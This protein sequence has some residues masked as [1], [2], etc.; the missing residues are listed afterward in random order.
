M[1]IKLQ[2]ERFNP[3]AD[4]KPGFQNFTVDAD[5]QSTI[6]EALLQIYENQD[7]TL[8]FRYGCRYKYC[9][10]CSV[11]ADGKAVLACLTRVKNG[12][13]LQPLNHLPVIRDLAVDRRY[14]YELLRKQEI[15]VKPKPK[16][17]FETLK[18]DEAY[19]VLSSCTEC[20]CCLSSC[21]NY[22]YKDEGFAGP[23]LFVKLARLQLDPRNEVDRK[24]Q[25]KRLGLDRCLSCSSFKRKRCVPCPAGISIYKHALLKLVG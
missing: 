17:E 3:E 16:K 22:S 14:L 15:Y 11:R 1:K 6:L 20:L 19:R 8:A 7:S 25:A 21:S 9:G 13:K 12:M 18:L 23:Y 4:E 10:L 5:K 2:I 24:Q